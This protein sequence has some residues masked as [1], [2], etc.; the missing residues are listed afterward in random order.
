MNNTEYESYTRRLVDILK[1]DSK[2]L[3]L[4]ALGSM[5]DPSYRDPWSDH[6]FWIIAE[7]EA[8]PFYRT[9]VSWLP[10]SHKILSVTYYKDRG[11][12]V[13]FRNQHGIEY[14]VF[15]LN[16][17][18]K[19]VTERYK[20]LFD[21]C[22]IAPQIAAVHKRTIQNRHEALE[23]NSALPQLCWTVWTGYA[24]HR[25]GEH[26]GAHKYIRFYAVNMLLD[27]FQYSGVL[28]ESGSTDVLDPWRRTEKLNPDLAREI[29]SIIDSD[30]PSGALRLLE[31]VKSRIQPYRPDLNWEAIEAIIS[32]IQETEEKKKK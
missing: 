32:W 25:R 14:A 13:L 30:I 28:K 11:A 4:V 12:A 26:L 24:R 20:I 1:R 8:L 23:W 15:D 2:V 5:A 3:G 18:S 21:R 9:S 19:A 22:N 27:L 29:R 16:D 17:M 10:D 6:D 7:P 31:L